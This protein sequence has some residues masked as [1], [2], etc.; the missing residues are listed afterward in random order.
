MTGLVAAEAWTAKPGP[1]LAVRA[2]QALRVGRRDDEWPGWV[3]CEDASGLGGWLP[4]TAVS[5]GRALEDFDARELTVSEGE[6]V[7]V[8]RRR[9]GW[10]WCR[11]AGGEGWVPERCLR[12]VA[13]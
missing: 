7:E 4:E 13:P 8:L 10:A 12:D 6:A 11:G 1:A 5:D 2:G 9:A 3:W